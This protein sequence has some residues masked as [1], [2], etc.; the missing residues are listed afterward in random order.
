[1]SAAKKHLAQALAGNRG[2]RLGLGGVGNIQLFVE[3]CADV[4]LGEMN[5]GRDDVRG[6]LAAQLHDVFAEVGFDHFASGPGERRVERDFL[7]R[8]R[9]ALDH[10]ARAALAGKIDDILARLGRVGGDEHAASVG[11]QA[12]LELDQQVVEP[13]DRILFYP[14]RG[15]ALGFVRR[16]LGARRGDVFEMASGGVLEFAAKFGV[17]HRGLARGEEI[18]FGGPLRPWPQ[19]H[20]RDT[21]RGIS[22]S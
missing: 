9:L 18:S 4:F 7:G 12:L 19:T 10:P 8:H 13:R 16:E 5:R 20:H 3:Q 21:Q 11:L 15:V 2:E 14:A 1:M 6:A 17:R 22:A